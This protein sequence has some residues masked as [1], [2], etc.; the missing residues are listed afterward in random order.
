MSEM[1]FDSDLRAL[2]QTGGPRADPG[3]IRDAVLRDVRTQRIYLWASHAFGLLVLAY[4]GWLDLQG[5][6]KFPGLMSIA[7]GGSI[8]WTAWKARLARKRCPNLALLSSQELLRLALRHARA[9]LRN[10]RACHTVLPLSVLAGMA[11]GPLLVVEDADAGEPAW[12]TAVWIV[13]ALGFI[14]GFV[15]F[16]LRLAKRKKREIRVLEKRLA[17]FDDSL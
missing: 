14:A 8:L 7:V 13:A 17:E 16:G 10:A 1:D 12:I 3:E 15:V 11:V 5:V 4:I 6:F 2:W 9:A